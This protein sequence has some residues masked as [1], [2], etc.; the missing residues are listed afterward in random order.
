MIGKKAAESA[1][2]ARVVRVTI[3]NDLRHKEMHCTK[4]YENGTMGT[5]GDHNS[6]NIHADLCLQRRNKP[7]YVQKV[8]YCIILLLSA[9]S[10]SL[11][12]QTGQ[13]MPIEA[14]MYSNEVLE[15]L[16]GATHFVVCQCSQRQFHSRDTASANK[17]TYCY[18]P[19]TSYH[20]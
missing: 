19:F 13:N 7:R 9:T 11:S 10:A 3:N 2:A 16:V 12:I 14:Q 5:A 4:Y 6:W 8:S 18:H 17:L 1:P 20:R 15:N